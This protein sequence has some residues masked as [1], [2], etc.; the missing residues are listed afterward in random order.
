MK[1][2]NAFMA[3]SHFI[4]PPWAYWSVA[5]WKANKEDALEIIE[6]MLGW[7]ITGFGS[8]DFYIRGLFLFTMWNGKLNVDK[9]PYAE[10]IMIVEKN[11]ETPMR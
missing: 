10:K 1:N 11:Q 8:G 5:D 4:L 9:K 7:D 2:A 3:E 6:N